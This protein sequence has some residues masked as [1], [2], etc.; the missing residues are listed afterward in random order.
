M[1]WYVEQGEELHPVVQ[2]ALQSLTGTV[3]RLVK[4][5]MSRIEALESRVAGLQQEVKDLRA[6][7]PVPMHGHV[8][9]SYYSAC[10]E[11]SIALLGDRLRSRGCGRARDRAP[12]CGADAPVAPPAPHLRPAGRIPERRLTR[13]R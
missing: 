9:S 13:R 6:R 5:Q 1:T 8:T 7:P 12:R 2:I 4:E 10:L 3:L 11:R